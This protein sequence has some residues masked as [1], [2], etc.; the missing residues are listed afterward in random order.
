MRSIPARRR[1]RARRCSRAQTPERATPASAPRPGACL[2]RFLVHVDRQRLPSRA[3]SR[4]VSFT[5]IA[6]HPP[7]PWNDRG[8]S[9]QALRIADAPV[10][11]RLDC[12]RRRLPAVRHSPL[13]CRRGSALLGRKAITVDV[14]RLEHLVDRRHVEPPAGRPENDVQVLPPGLTSFSG[15]RSCCR[16]RRDGCRRT[17]QP[18]T[19]NS[20]LPV[21]ALRAQTG[22]CSC[23]ALSG[24]RERW[25]YP[26]PIAWPTG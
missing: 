24:S 1:R 8:R 12:T 25:K 22:N 19:G 17:R 6:E 21:N 15:S 7:F 4:H 2:Q 26:T 11:S 16:G 10:R 9:A 20:P 3:V 13:Q 23:P 18:R 14:Q 5:M